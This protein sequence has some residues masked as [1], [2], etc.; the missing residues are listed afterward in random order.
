MNRV[1]SAACNEWTVVSRKNR[2]HA[3]SSFSNQSCASVGLQDNEVDLKF[4]EREKGKIEKT[5]CNLKTSVFYQAWWKILTDVLKHVTDSFC[6]PIHELVC[7]GLGSITGNITSRIQYS[8]LLHMMDHINDLFDSQV[9]CYSYDPAFSSL[10][11]A[12]MKGLVI[13]S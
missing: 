2:K 8:M 7:Y 5:K 6:L 11:I 13:D 9:P 10:D 1:M 3:E 4:F 12:I